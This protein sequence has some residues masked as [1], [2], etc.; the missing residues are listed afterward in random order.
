[1]EAK[2]VTGAVTYDGTTVTITSRFARGA[3]SV[4]RAAITGVQWKDATRLVRG[5]LQLVVPGFGQHGNGPRDQQP[6]FE[7]IR[8]AIQG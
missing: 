4:P 7:A 1:M 8:A 5:H 6:A 3:T 2:G